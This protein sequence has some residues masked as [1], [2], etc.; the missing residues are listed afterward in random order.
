MSESP[1]YN[2]TLPEALKVLDTQ[3]LSNRRQTESGQVTHQLEGMSLDQAYDVGYETLLHDLKTITG[4]DP[5][6]VSIVEV[7][8]T[9]PEENTNA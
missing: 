2:L 9:Y 6:E 3:A 7:P 5:L 8:I 1:K 4:P